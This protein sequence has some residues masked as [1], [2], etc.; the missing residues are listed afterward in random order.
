MYDIRWTTRLACATIALTA[1]GSIGFQARAQWLEQG[2]QASLTSVFWELARYFT[3]LTNALVA[4]ALADTA[5][6]GRWQNG[7]LPAALTV[8]IV[9]V[10]VVYHLLLSA[11]HDP[12]GWEIWANIG[13]HSI[14][15]AAMLALW[16]V[17][18]PK[19]GL[20]LVHPAIWSLWPLLYA[21]YAILRG[22]R[23]GIYPYFFLDPVTSGIGVVAAYV[24]GLGVF[25]L[26]SGA[27]LV[28]LSRLL[29]PV[30]HR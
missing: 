14:V 13:E 9:A 1:A 6:R 26:A 22:I 17:A 2:D 7:S 19:T 24:F 30:A 27:G 3:H 18:A 29:P 28:I 10:G 5:L 21:V 8:W 12:Q 4:L 20:T 15:P 25:F 16:L 11:S 23:D